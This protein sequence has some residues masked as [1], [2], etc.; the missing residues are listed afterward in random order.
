MVFYLHIFFTVSL[1][2]PELPKI[3]SST[4][5]EASNFLTTPSGH[6]LQLTD[7]VEA[8]SA[9]ST[10]SQPGNLTSV[11]PFSQSNHNLSSPTVPSVLPGNNSHNIAA[12]F[13][14]RTVPQIEVSSSQSS[15][16][17]MSDIQVVPNVN[18]SSVNH[19]AIPNGILPGNSMIHP[20]NDTAPLQY[21]NMTAPML[22]HNQDMSAVPQESSGVYHQ[23]NLATP[24]SYPQ[25]NMATPVL[26]PQHDMTTP[27]S[28]PQNNMAAPLLYP[29]N[30][31]T[32]SQQNMTTPESYPQHITA[33]V[34]NSQQHLNT[35]GVHP[36]QN[37]P[38]PL[39]Y[40]QQD[41]GSQPLLNTHPPPES[42][43]MRVPQQTQVIPPG[44]TPIHQDQASDW[45]LNPRVAHGPLP[46]PPTYEDANMMPSYTP[47]QPPLPP[48]ISVPLL[49]ENGPHNTVPIVHLPPANTGHAPL[50]GTNNM[51]TQI[52]GHP[53]HHQ[54]PNGPLFTN[55]GQ[56]LQGTEPV[57]VPSSSGA[58]HQMVQPVNQTQPHYSSQGSRSSD[59]LSHQPALQTVVVQR[60][61]RRHK[62]EQA[63]RIAAVEREWQARER[64]ERERQAALERERQAALE[65]ER[66]A[67]LERERQ[68]AL[69]N[70]R[71]ASIER[72]RQE[73]LLLDREKEELKR[74]HE[75]LEVII[76]RNTATEQQVMEL[77]DQLQAREKNLAAKE[78]EQQAMMQERQRLQEQKEREITDIEQQLIAE[79]VALQQQLEQHQ[80]DLVRER[81]SIQ[82]HKIAALKEVEKEKETV[83][84]QQKQL[85][86]QQQ[87]MNEQMAQ[88]LQ[89]RNRSNRQIQVETGLP[90]GW[91][92]KFDQTTG[93]FYY[94]DHNTKTT[95]WN[96]PSS[97]LTHGNPAQPKQPPLH[98]T[99][100][101]QPT[102][103]T[104]GN[105]PKSTSGQLQP[106]A[107]VSKTKL[108]P[109]QTTTDHTPSVGPS[110]KP[111]AD[112]GAVVVPDRSTKPQSQPSQTNRGSSSTVP[113]NQ[114]PPHVWKRKMENLQPVHG[115]SMVCKF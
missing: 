61:N 60:D 95:H 75:E 9:T 62:Q 46:M 51:A 89:T 33:P 13:S 6:P 85:R 24:M 38:T 94:Q 57:P 29:Q 26:Y 35:R 12:S 83:L 39:P 25:Q 109:P 59:H 41:M 102:T 55:V 17:N 86:E 77:R 2:Y 113:V 106:L 68:V 50:S 48:P 65:M 5:N 14:D 91:E 32:T 27:I 87:N 30:G 64:Q 3:D 4:T 81:E 58:H 80:S 8:N 56:G 37:T 16:T 107:S 104:T 67:A 49:P 103:L 71:L 84:L 44:T 101:T 40:A 53:A 76:S 108:P 100:N 66:Q 115:G 11:E 78:S 47:V 72:E 69:E 31:M 105:V 70:E 63:E 18:F 99:T 45:G 114:I 7:S 98:V 42:V 34:S 96:P 23:Q 88:W 21:P 19:N 74:R 10:F 97:W 111:V 90:V 36:Q 43:P 22:H 73:R 52:P 1:D 112:N 54:Q 92:K 110:A 93:R 28:Y 15:V 82:Q 79:R 20:M